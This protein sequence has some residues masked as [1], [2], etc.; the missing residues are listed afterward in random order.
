MSDQPKAPPTAEETERQAEA[1]ARYFAREIGAWRE[2]CAL[3]EISPTN[4]TDM[5]QVWAAARMDLGLS[6]EEFWGRTPQEILALLK[7][8][9][10]LPKTAP[11]AAASEAAPPAPNP[12]ATL[13]GCDR[14]SVRTAAAALGI[15]ERWVRDLL[16][17]GE[18]EA[19]GAGHRRRIT[20]ES[21][22]ERLGLQKKS[23]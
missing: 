2:A 12:E 13:A 1:V 22:R 8:R 15:S 23:T 19:V 4:E 18:L 21:I 17:R 6:D 5:L 11:M 3:L 20:S 9:L 16:N 10:G 7:R 14:V